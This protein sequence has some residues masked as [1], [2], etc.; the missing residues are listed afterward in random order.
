M[1]DVPKGIRASAP[2]AIVIEMIGAMRNRNPTLVAGRDASLVAN[3]M[4]SASGWNSPNGPT[5]LGP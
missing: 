1:L 5:R 3:L 2:T 4:I